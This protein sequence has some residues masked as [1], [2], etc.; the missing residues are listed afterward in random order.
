MMNRLL[1]YY[2]YEEI[3]RES[4]NSVTRLVASLAEGLQGDYEVFM[5]SFESGQGNFPVRSNRIIIKVPAWRKILRKINNTVGLKR[6]HWRMVQKVSVK[7]DLRKRSEKFDAVIV[8]GLDDVADAR[9]LF[10]SAKIVYWIHNISALCKPHY[11]KLVNLADYFVTPSRKAYHFL[12]EKLQPQP[13]L[14]EYFF[15]PNWCEPVF[16]QQH[17]ERVAALRSGYG[18]PDEA[19]VFIFAGGDH[20]VKGKIMINKILQ[21]LD[22]KN[23]KNLV[24]I[25]AGSKQPKN[26]LQL[27][28]I[29]VIH[30]G[31]LS[32]SELAAHYQLA[33]IG[34]FPSL[35]YDHTPLTLLEMTVSG[36]LPV[37]SDIG[38]VK[39]ILG[40]DYPFLVEEPH[41]SENWFQKLIALLM[42]TPGQRDE[43]A[44][45]L[46]E[47]IINVYN[48]EKALS[49]MRE[50]LITGN[51]K[52]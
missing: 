47:K 17:S 48:N 12:Q 6:I 11:L 14:A 10:P 9:D 4:N 33:D 44:A 5:L 21:R 50:I 52:E 26:I 41:S 30:A 40:A 2:Y 31:L 39:E 32:L 34:L 16:M 51:S 20:P 13:L 24:F 43:I 8:L 37:A 38:G 25:L 49:V 7:D 42:L 35:G 3:T 22:D 36:V 27:G 28:E 46:R 18:I 19:V 15:M 29:L 1:I 23:L 45:G